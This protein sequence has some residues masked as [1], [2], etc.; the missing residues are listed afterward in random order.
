M[1][2]KVSTPRAAART[3]GPLA[4]A[5][6]AVVAIVLLVGGGGDPANHR[7]FATVKDATNLIKGQELKAGG[8]KIGV[9]EKVA[10]V[11]GGR[12]ARL[13]LAVEDRAWPLPRDTTFTARFGGTASFYNRHIL[14]T[15]GKERD[16]PLAE[17][18]NIPAGNFRIPVE[19]DQLLAVF[20]GKARTDLKAFI[21]RSGDTLARSRTPLVKVFTRTP[22]ALDQAVH[23][24]EDLTAERDAL[25]T[26]LVRTDDV[27]D[28]VRRADPN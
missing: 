16:T 5:L 7:L 2:D 1:S 8:G 11:A 24:F 28:A 27:V 26:T 3:V 4:L 13:T 15:P 12:R 14:V 18:G 9:I 21:N 22:P 19:V 6:A 25:D 10:P 23:V 17:N 20:D